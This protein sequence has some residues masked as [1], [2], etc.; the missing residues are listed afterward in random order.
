VENKFL[1]VVDTYIRNGLDMERG[2][3]GMNSDTKHWI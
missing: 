3:E 1:I 2:T